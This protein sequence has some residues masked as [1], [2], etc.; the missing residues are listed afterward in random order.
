ME[1]TILF[2]Q[3]ILPSF[4]RC[5]KRPLAKLNPFTGSDRFP[6]ESEEEP[7]IRYIV[8]LFEE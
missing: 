5:G 2:N 4:S 3:F 6:R 7:I 8:L 1:T